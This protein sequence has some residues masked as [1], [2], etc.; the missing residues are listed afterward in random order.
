V[1]AGEARHLEGLA[2]RVRA[3]DPANLLARGWTITRR[4]DGTIVKRPDEL[5]AGDVIAT[6][7]AAGTVTSR[8]EDH[9]R[10]DP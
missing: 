10:N 2:A 6:Q 7:F 9:P 8:V 5:V 4:A 3:L 1:L